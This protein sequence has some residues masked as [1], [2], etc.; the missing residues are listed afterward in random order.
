MRS[1][2]P[3][4]DVYIQGYTELNPKIVQHFRVLHDA[5]DCFI[6]IVLVLN[7]TLTDNRVMDGC[8]NPS[9]PFQLL[10]DLGYC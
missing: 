4:T 9:N 7:P 2:R 5:P 6:H 10:I 3:P 1:P 8:S